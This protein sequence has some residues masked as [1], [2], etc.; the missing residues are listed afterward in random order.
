[1]SKQFSTT[2]D[3]SSEK[4]I[5]LSARNQEAGQM[6]V[7]WADLGS[8]NMAELVLIAQSLDR[9]NTDVTISYT[10]FDEQ[11]EIMSRGTQMVALKAIPDSYALHNNFP[12]PFNPVT[13]IFYD[14][15]KSGHVRMVIYDLLGRE[16]TT[17][18]NETMKSGYYSTRW[19]GRNQYGQPVGAG[20][21]FYH[22]HT[23]A[24]SKAQK[25]LLVK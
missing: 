14:L 24:Y 6:L 5:Y 25:M 1:M 9:S 8:E 18:I 11:K 13:N 7:E 16:V 4:Q 3:V 19:N 12:N 15:P 20:I 22:L 21:Y 17:L 23:D 2:T 10:I